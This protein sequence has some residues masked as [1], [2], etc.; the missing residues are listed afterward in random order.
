MLFTITEN[1]KYVIVRKLGGF[2]KTKYDFVS[3][4]AHEFKGKKEVVGYL[5]LA[6]ALHYDSAEEA[7]A[8]LRT[9]PEWVRND[10][11]VMPFE[12]TTYDCFVI[13]DAE[14]YTV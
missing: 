5:D 2:D 9:Q 12:Y 1:T 3:Q 8:V 6:N 11:E 10:H 13:V 4:L 14:R 7:L